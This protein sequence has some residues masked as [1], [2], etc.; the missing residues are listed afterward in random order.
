MGVMG[1]RV[2]LVGGLDFSDR[3]FGEGSGSWA[4]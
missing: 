4:T 3:F 2:L 1:V